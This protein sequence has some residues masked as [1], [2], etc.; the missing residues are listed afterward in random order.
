MAQPDGEWPWIEDRPVF[1][2]RG[3][4]G[5][6]VTAVPAGAVLGSFT[7]RFRLVVAGFVVGVA[8][9][10]VGAGLVVSGPSGGSSAGSW[11]WLA[12]AVPAAGF[13]LLQFAGVYV[14]GMPLM[15]RERPRN[16]LLLAGLFG[17][18]APG[19]AVLGALNGAEGVLL[20]AAAA[21]AFGCAVA[22]AFAVRG[23]RRARRDVVR[24]LRLRASGTAYAGTITG[25]P[26][27]GTWNHGGDVPVRYRDGDDGAEHTVTVRVNT[28][29]HEIPVPGTRVI[30]RRDEDG[31]LL[32]ELDPAHP[33]EYH[34]DSRS[35]EQDTSGGGSM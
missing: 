24:I 7:R 5:G 14:E 15:M 32:V 35:Y 34:P 26:D 9:A 18:V 6:N 12:L 33:V 13:A 29:A 19:L 25:L 21:A 31:D 27:P 2:T 28:W 1:T 4:R 30:V 16:L 23:I 11:W 3:E 22:G 10:V 8:G 20:L 17:G